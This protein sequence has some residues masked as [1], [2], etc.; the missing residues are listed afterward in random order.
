MHYAIVRGCTAAD[1]HLRLRRLR[2]GNGAT[3]RTYLS[4]LQNLTQETMQYWRK[5]LMPEAKPIRSPSR[6]RAHQ[7]SSAADAA[8][9]EGD[10]GVDTV[11]VWGGVGV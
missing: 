10:E 6:E 7:S 9:Q 3:P 1:Q 4:R 2:D 8:V 11:D 5:R